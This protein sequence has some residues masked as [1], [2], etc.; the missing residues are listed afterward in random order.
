VVAIPATSLTSC[1]AGPTE[2][3][4]VL[5]GRWGGDGFSL[6]VTTDS[7]SARF[8]CAYG[9]LRVPIPL[10]SEGAF[11]VEGDFVREIGPAALGNPARYEGQVRGIRI[12]LRVLV[13]DTVFGTGTSTL[14]PFEGLRDGEARVAY[15][16]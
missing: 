16:Q 7:A 8:A 1:R 15:C 3:P 4:D 5:T 13:T 2:I 10:S 6:L 9:E 11:S 12:S 14:G